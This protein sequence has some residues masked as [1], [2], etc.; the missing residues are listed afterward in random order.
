MVHKI[1][2]LRIRVCLLGVSFLSLSGG[3]FMYALFRNSD[4][5]I[6]D[7]FGF[8]RGMNSVYVPVGS[9]PA[10]LFI[11]NSL[12]GGLWFLAGILFLRSI[13][14]TNKKWRRIY[15]FLFCL[16]A[17]FLETAQLFEQVPGTFDFFDMLC[18][19]TFAL[20]EGVFYTIFIAKEIK[21][22]EQKMASA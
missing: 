14:L 4:L 19:G 5:L 11:V 3:M 21:N 22:Y 1:P 15:V 18:F 6:F 16:A 13:W 12:P 8:L 9:S 10:L 17:V 7:W 20:L 2:L